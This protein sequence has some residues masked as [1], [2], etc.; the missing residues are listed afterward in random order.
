MKIEISCPGRQPGEPTA[1][2]DTAPEGTTAAPDRA[3]GVSTARAATP[4]DALNVEAGAGADPPAA[5]CPPPPPAGDIATG[6]TS[7]A[8]APLPATRADPDGRTAEGGFAPGATPPD[9]LPAR[10]PDTAPPRRAATDAPRSRP[11]DP[12]ADESGAE[13]SAPRLSA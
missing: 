5:E 10:A 1:A 13:E 11:G 4:A 6:V 2:P 7:S 3:F 12:D 9:T 8:T